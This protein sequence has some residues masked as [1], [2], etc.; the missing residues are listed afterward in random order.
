MSGFAVFRLLYSLEF[1]SDVNVTD[2]D[3]NL[4]TA[5]CEHRQRAHRLPEPQALGRP[6]PPSP[7][8]RSP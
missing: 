6:A 5:T 2:T 7:P 8:R 4:A 3:S 1:G